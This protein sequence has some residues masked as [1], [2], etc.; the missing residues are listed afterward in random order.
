LVSEAISILNAIAFPAGQ[1]FIT[2]ET[3]KPYGSVANLPNPPL[4]FKF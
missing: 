1:S 2:N 3:A 4:L